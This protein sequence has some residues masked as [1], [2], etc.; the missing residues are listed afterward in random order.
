MSKITHYP[1][2]PRIPGST[3][4]LGLMCIQGGHSISVIES[5]QQ[6]NQQDWVAF[7]SQPYGVQ[8]KV[9]VDIEAEVETRLR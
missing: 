9:K 1:L 3:P 4:V 2:P 7:M 5:Q 6:F 8:V